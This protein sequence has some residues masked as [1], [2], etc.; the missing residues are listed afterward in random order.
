MWLLVADVCVAAT[1]W[2][3]GSERIRVSFIKAN[4]RF[5]WLFGIRGQEKGA[6]S[7]TNGALLTSSAFQSQFLRVSGVERILTLEQWG[8]G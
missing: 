4:L 7:H 3:V 1:E 5:V 6:I 2:W 8:L